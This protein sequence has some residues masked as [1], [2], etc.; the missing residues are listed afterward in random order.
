MLVVLAIPLIFVGLGSYSLVNGD[1]GIYHAIAVHMVNSGD[2][3]HL[4]FTGEHAIYPTFMN[5]PLQYWTRAA[6]IAFFGDSYWTMRIGSA[7]FAL[8]ALLVT[9]R[10]AV[11][12]AGQRIAF[13]AGLILLTTVQFVYLHGARTGELEPVVLFALTLTAHWF[14]RAVQTGRGFVAHFLAMLLL[15]AMKTPTVLIPLI[16]ELACF[17]AVPV[18]RSHFKRWA[19]I[20]LLMLPLGVVWHVARLVQL[21][22][23]FREVAVTMAGE[24]SGSGWVGR[25]VSNALFYAKTIVFGAFPYSV[26]YPLAVV[27]LVRRSAWT[28]QPAGRPVVYAFLMA[29]LGFYL[30]VAKHHPWYVMPAYPFLSILTATWLARLA[31][32]QM[33]LTLLTALAFAG[34]LLIC[35]VV[36]IADFN[37]F[38]EQAFRISM[39]VAWRGFRD[40]SVPTTLCAA[41]MC[42]A[43]GL[44]GLRSM[45]PARF[46]T[47]VAAALAVTLISYAALRVAAP[48]RFLGYQSEM[49]KLHDQL[50][51]A[52]QSGQPI[53]YPVRIP[54]KG[55]IAARYYFADDFEIVPRFHTAE[56]YDLM[57]F[58][59]NDPRVVGRSGSH[60]HI[61]ALP[62]E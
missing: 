29:S 34:A 27:T 20:G 9:Y 45:L 55:F 39:A 50:E 12:V 24:A 17:I 59:K 49:A 3:I 5:A 40:L 23:P 6:L 38:A 53:D 47:V 48:L 41:T 15:M 57:L 8:A 51:A 44:I 43:L 52:L 25:P 36:P 13:L 28:E 11:V 54:D 33:G 37:P 10:F 58:E 7:L 42:L 30:L 46:P 14:L 26:I 22:E 1:E 4:Y 21:W 56:Y 60:R 19:L 2:W 35:V 18:F 31:Q 16:A 32:E 61:F 62:P